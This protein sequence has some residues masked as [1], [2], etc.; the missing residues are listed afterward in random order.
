MAFFWYLPC[1]KR[2]AV[3]CSNPPQHAYTGQ[4]VTELV[5]VILLQLTYFFFFPRGHT[6]GSLVISTKLEA[7]VRVILVKFIIT[8]IF[9]LVLSCKVICTYEQ[10]TGIKLDIGELYCFKINISQT[11]YQNAT[12]S[13][14]ANISIVL[15]CLRSYINHVIGSI[16]HDEMNVSLKVFPY[17]LFEGKQQFKKYY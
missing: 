13:S 4:L 9:W 10:Q 12:F 3:F 8:T 11:H 6:I 17:L 15:S 5:S 2:Y 14:F 16:F 1:E 7:T